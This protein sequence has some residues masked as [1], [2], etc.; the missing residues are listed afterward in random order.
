MIKG[1]VRDPVSAEGDLLGQISATACA[2]RRIQDLCAIHGTE[3]FLRT[4][5]RLHDLSETEMREAIHALP[6]G[7]Y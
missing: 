3:T 1:N 6:D 2:E 4:I 7:V 5:A